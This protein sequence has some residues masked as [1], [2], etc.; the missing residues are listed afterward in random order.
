MTQSAPRVDSRLLAAIE[1]FDDRRRPIAETYRQIGL[2]AEAIGL[3]RPSYEQVRKLVHDRRNGRLNP[4]AG[5]VLLDI[6]FR[7]AAP[8]A[9]LDVLAGT[10]SLP[11]RAK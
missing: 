11:R 10:H 9:L 8:D 3:P 2:I 6:A 1:R 7:V 5:E 4:G